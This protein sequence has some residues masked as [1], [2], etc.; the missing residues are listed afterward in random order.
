LIIFA[1]VGILEYSFF[2]LWGD[3]A[4]DARPCIA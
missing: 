3:S 4:I 2:L 1:K